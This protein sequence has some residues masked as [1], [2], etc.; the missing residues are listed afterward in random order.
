VPSGVASERESPHPVGPPPRNPQLFQRRRAFVTCW[1]SFEK[2]ASIC[3]EPL[4]AAYGKRV[5]SAPNGDR[6]QNVRCFKH[7]EALPSPP[8]D[9]RHDA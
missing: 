3:V 5:D 1:K 4:N 9:K 2:D 6:G 8:G 7:L